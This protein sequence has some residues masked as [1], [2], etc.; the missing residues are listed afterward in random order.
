MSCEICCDSLS[1]SIEKDHVNCLKQIVRNYSPGEDDFEMTIVK[2]SL[3]CAKFLLDFGCPFWDTEDYVI[4]SN[5]GLCYI[6]VEYGHL[7][8][9]KWMHEVNQKKQTF[10]VGILGSLRRA[11]YECNFEILD[12][13]FSIGAPFFNEGEKF[14]EFEYEYDGR[15]RMLL[16]TMDN[17]EIDDK[18][19]KRCF[20]IILEKF[21]KT[22][23]WKDFEKM[24]KDTY[25]SCMYK[26]KLECM[27]ILTNTHP[28]Q[29]PKTHSATEVRSAD[30]KLFDC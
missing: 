1:G 5:R 17:D 25:E 19:K 21:Y 15:R 27:D 4:D 3:K 16:D 24:C 12:F 10:A 9:I 14:G 30:H 26:G 29:L 6:A 8:I 23:E 28:I 7:D 18:T 13:F 20:M 22:M 11:A 2:G